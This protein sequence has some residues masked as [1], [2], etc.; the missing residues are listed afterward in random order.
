ML[1]C[2]VSINIDIISTMDRINI[3]KADRKPNLVDYLTIVSKRRIFIYKIILIGAMTS[4]II[5]LCLRN[6]YK[7]TT[8][9][10]P[11]NPQ[12]DLMFGFAAPSV[13][14]SFGGYS[15]ITSLLAGGT[16][17]SD[18]FASILSSA[19]VTGAIIR[20]F[21]LRKVFK[22][23]TYHDAHKKLEEITSIGVSPE[24][25]IEVS[26]IWYDKQL[27]AD[28]AN[29]YIDELDQF[30]TEAAM[31]VGKKYRIFI[32]ERLEQAIDTLA[33]A[34]EALRD[35]QEEH[36]T[37]ALDAEIQAAIET[38]AQLKS[39]IILHEVQKGAWSAAGQADNPY[40]YSINRDL[41]EL[42][43]QLAKIEFGKKDEATQ[44]FGAGF[45]V[46]FTKLP[47]VSLEY[48]RLYR[49]VKVQ[50]A[51]FELLTQQYEQ[52]KIME[53]K[54]TPTV[55]VL[56]RASAPEKKT[57]PRRS[58]IVIFA[59]FASLIL[60]VL[61]TFVLESFE[62]LKL[63]ADEYKKWTNIYNKINNDIKKIKTFISKIV[64]IRAKRS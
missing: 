50:E 16:G 8:T 30:N 27:A 51:I 41:R 32:E 62:Q 5:S 12:Q 7:A 59:S 14:G 13:V 6:Q 34:E 11:P 42:K 1:G 22:V 10:L 64:P 2:D 25:M 63:R 23:K 36:R 39:Q 35:F 4:L 31:S 40:L 58:R 29:A 3:M 52:A 55:Q 46:P 24:G 47:E 54:D 37:V 20:K 21:E 49:D 33:K 57:S 18:L 19:R 56:D 26:V 61:G 15:G 17:P 48:A 45:S 38:V 9:I 44:E 60:G 43:K 28:I 53:V